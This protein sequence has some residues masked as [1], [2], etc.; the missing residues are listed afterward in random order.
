VSAVK[1]IAS[2]VRCGKEILVSDNGQ[3][4][5]A[6]FL[7]GEK[8]NLVDTETGRVQTVYLNK[9][10]LHECFKHDVKRRIALLDSVSKYG[11]EV[12]VSN[13]ISYVYGVFPL[14]G[15]TINAR[16]HA[17]PKCGTG[18]ED[19]CLNMTN[20]KNRGK[21]NRTIHIERVDHALEENGLYALTRINGVWLGYVSI[22]K[23][24]A[25]MSAAVDH[26]K[27]AK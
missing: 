13:D 21:P 9:V 12:A 25:R 19:P 14:S 27:G 7:E 4:F 8:A 1:P 18:S 15:K 2:C 16:N 10:M 5:R 17:C 20:S 23:I 6:E 26:S 3:Q 11:E 22:R 24:P